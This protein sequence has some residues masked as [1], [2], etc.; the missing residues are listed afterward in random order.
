M[1]GDCSLFLNQSIP[2]LW[3]DPPILY[4]AEV[5]TATL[6]PIR[7]DVGGKKTAAIFFR[8]TFF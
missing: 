4:C 6:V 3:E 7:L 2:K 1:Q 5:S 8:K